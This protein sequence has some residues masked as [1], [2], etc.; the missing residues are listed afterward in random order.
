[1]SAGSGVELSSSILALC[2]VWV[3]CFD[4]MRGKEY[5]VRVSYEECAVYQRQQ[6]QHTWHD[7]TRC[8]S[9]LVGPTPATAPTV[10]TQQRDSQPNKVTGNIVFL[11]PAANM[12]YTSASPSSFYSSSS[13]SSASS[14]SSGS[15]HTY[16]P[17]GVLCWNRDATGPSPAASSAA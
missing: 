15:S 10:G 7:T 6:Q 17:L 11:Q 12:V 16:G 1:M 2:I 14:S 8:C 3:C 13:S 5:C 4:A 9:V